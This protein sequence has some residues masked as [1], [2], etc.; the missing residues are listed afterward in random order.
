MD[1]FYIFTYEDSNYLYQFQ[2]FDTLEQL[3]TFKEQLED[4]KD[5]RNILMIAVVE[6]GEMTFLNPDD[7]SRMP[8][9]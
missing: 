4:E 2:K 6:N 7:L 8:K 3:Q 9:E 1:I 5:I